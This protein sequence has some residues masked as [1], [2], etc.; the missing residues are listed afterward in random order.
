MS[1]CLVRAVLV[2]AVFASLRPIPASA[3]VTAAVPAREIAGRV[4]DPAGLPVP[5][6]TV[7]L[8]NTATGLGRIATSDAAGAYR[9]TDLGDGAYRLNVTIDGFAPASR[10]ATPG[11]RADVEV[12]PAQVVESVTVVSGA[13]QAELRES[14]STPVNVV[15]R[16]RL[17]DTAR[18]SVGE[19][20]R[21]VPGVLTRRG[22]EGTT[23]AGEQVQGIDS[24][25]VLV[26][27]DGQPIAG[28]RGIK[29]GAINLDRQSTYRLERVE[30][31]KGA[32][33]ALFGSDA[34]GGVINLIT[35]DASS[36]LE[37]MATVSGGEHGTVDAAATAGGRRGRSS[38]FGTVSRSERDSFDLTPT[39]PDTT[40][41]HFTRHDGFGRY[42]FRPTSA[43]TFTATGSGYWNTQSGRVAGEAGLLDSVVDDQ[44]QAAALSALLQVGGR[45]SVESRLY[46]TRFEE[47]NASTLF[48]TQVVQP[49]DRLYESLVKGDASV[50]HVLG[51]R[52]LLQAGAEF[53]GDRY[54]GV[55]RVRDD[56]GHEATTSV[57]WA[58]DRI[59]LASWLT[60]TL[61]GRYD[62][63]STFG[64][65][66]SPKAAFNVRVV[67]GVR[68]RASYGEGFRAPDLGQLF[69]RFVPSANFYQVIG[70]PDLEAEHAESWQVG[71]DYSHRSGRVRFGVNAFRNDVNDLVEA[72]SLGFIAT[73]AQ[74][75]A[76]LALEN[77]DPSFRPVFGRQ[78]FVY[79]NVA[80]ARTEGIEVDGEAALGGSFQLAGA[81]TYLDAL[82]L[83]RGQ[84]LA[85]RHRH[86]GHT[87]LTWSRAP[88]GLRAEIRGTFYSSWIAVASRSA[89]DPGV[90]APG[91]ALW[92]A[93][94]AKRIAGGVEV[95]GALDN[96][97][98]NQDPNSGIV[99]PAGT[100][101][102]I[103]RAEIGRAIRCGVRW[104][105]DKK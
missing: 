66:F 14:L 101:A 69:Y 87:R 19:V 43:L 62:H 6:A 41:V 34:I 13:R 64:S 42:G 55:N 92:D 103:Y 77:L 26:L 59:S 30:V 52:H 47:T 104:T 29:S 10:E 81:Y 73:P 79:R 89:A 1:R 35:R 48:V 4:V 102:P 76:V 100:P 57:A 67:D 40:G 83:T 88:L 16:S 17:E 51:E 45:T 94:A 60:L 27:V 72:H 54:R 3:Q 8:S 24:R 21:E 28:A 70:N 80:D 65:Q 15:T 50:S 58:Q 44:S 53:A 36:P 96:L 5:G 7:V 39:T 9:F 97:T 82:D 38:I 2:A 18:S 99:L 12:R 37:T 86:Q 61:G 84:S 33:S 105:F 71:A 68:I 25:Q 56:D 31:V 85:G 98:D 11:S 74:L 91:F 23:I 46:W 49:T 93:Y 75:A 63:H 90:R 20:L 95:F 32:A 78:L 22:S